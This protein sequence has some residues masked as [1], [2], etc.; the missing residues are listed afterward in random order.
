[1]ITY[2]SVDLQGD[3]FCLDIVKGLHEP[4]TARGKDS[5][6]PGQDGRYA[7]NRKKDV[8]RILLEGYIRGVGETLQE[9]RESFFDRVE[10]IMST[11][12]RSAAPGTLSV[13]GGTY[14]LGAGEEWTIN[15]RCIN[16]MGGPMMAQWTAQ[17][18]SIELESV[19]PDW[20]AS[21]S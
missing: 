9:R 1:M 5:I 21:G 14:G 7:R 20:V 13:D 15:A 12:D 8:R 4:A 18:F 17:E 16:V 10:G 11:M 3:G 19:D 2:R 6:A